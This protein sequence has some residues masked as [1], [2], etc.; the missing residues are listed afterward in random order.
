MIQ[1]YDK[2]LLLKIA[3]KLKLGQASPE[4]QDY[5]D[6]WYR[7]HKDDILELP[8]GYVPHVEMIRDRMHE[9]IMHR[10]TAEQFPKNKK[11][12]K[13]WWS[14]AAAALLIMGLFFYFQNNGNVNGSDPK[15]ATV[16]TVILPGT[17][18]ATLTLSDGKKIK[19]SDI[20]TGQT[21]KADGALIT[22]A[23]DGSLIYEVDHTFTGRMKLNTVATMN[24]ETY[25]INLPD[26]TLVWLNAGSS[27]KYPVVFD[28][29]ERKVTLTGEAYF[30]V[31]SN[32]KVP[33]SVVSGKQT[34]EVLG[35][36]FNINAYDNEKYIK[37]T[38]LEGRVK[39]KNDDVVSI[40][41]VGQQSRVNK[42]KDGID[43][44]EVDLEEA[45]AWKEGYFRFNNE[46]I[47]SVM[48]KVARW[49]N[50]DVS[51]Q[52]VISKEKFNGTVSRNKD[53]DQ[54]LEI[55]E[56]T[57]AVHFKIKGRRVT[58]ME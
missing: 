53:I 38:L 54:V 7:E 32:K 50:I 51:F 11:I 47:E 33:F 23:A 26:G 55:L 14:I 16:D 18:S 57:N 12:P 56:L 15:Q 3:Y 40:L 22:K 35:T 29:K 41:N 45:V 27:L 48:R 46:S 5:F 1:E 10:I 36:H 6:R 37:T 31:A 9:K 30:E 44:L 4:E 49:Y 2:E 39:V 43:V 21:V 42:E 28:K 25:T 52:G 17:Q 20:K 34:V 24:G 13:K 58:V 19:L 8:E